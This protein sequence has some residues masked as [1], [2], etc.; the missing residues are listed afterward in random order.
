[1]GADDEL[2]GEREGVADVVAM[3]RSVAAGLAARDAEPSARDLEWQRWASSAL[4]QVKMT[5]RSQ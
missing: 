5:G 3:T 2:E 4:A 1:M